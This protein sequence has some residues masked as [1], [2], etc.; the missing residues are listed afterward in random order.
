MLGDLELQAGQEHQ[1]LLGTKSRRWA[2]W[3]II[4]CIV[5]YSPQLRH[6]MICQIGPIHCFP[7]PSV[8]ATIAA[9]PWAAA[10]PRGLCVGACQ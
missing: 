9:G 6:L 8:I 1:K 5:M 3:Y 2:F 4:W 7:H 10:G